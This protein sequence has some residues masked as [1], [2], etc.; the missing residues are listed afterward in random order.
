MID[1]IQMSGHA[2]KSDIQSRAE[3]DVAGFQSS[4]GPFVVAAEKTR[5][6]MAFTPAEFSAAVAQLVGG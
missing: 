2:R 4:L 1:G 5:M 6:A 3:A